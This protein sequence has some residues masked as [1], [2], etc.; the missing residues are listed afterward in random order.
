MPSLR[1]LPAELHLNIAA[2]LLFKPN[3]TWPVED[4]Q[5][6]AST[7]ALRSTSRYWRRMIDELID[8]ADQER[9]RFYRTFQDPLSLQLHINKIEFTLDT[10]AAQPT[11][12]SKDLRPSY[13]QMLETSEDILRRQ[14]HRQE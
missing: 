13:K 11:W 12:Y 14:N 6:T 2:Q 7:R 9:R 4:F 5:D 1:D 10:M 8:N 3:P